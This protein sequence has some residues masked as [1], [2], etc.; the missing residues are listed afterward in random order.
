MVKYNASSKGAPRAAA[1]RDAARAGLLSGL[2]AAV[3]ARRNAAGLT[4]KDLAARADV[5]ERFLVQ[6]EG[7]T[8]N[9][10]VV[11][12][13]DVAAALGTTGAVLLSEVSA[14]GHE[15]RRERDVVALVGLRGAGKSAVGASLAKQRRVPF[16]ELDAL[17]A[18]EARMSL[19]A[20]F[21]I[22]GEGYYRRLEREVLQ[23]VLEETPRCVLAT[24]GSLVTDPETWSLLRGR[25]RTVWLSAS[26]R[27]HW[28]RVVAQG[29]ARPMRGRPAAM[30]ELEDLLA[31]RRPLY[32]MAHHAIDTSGAALSEVVER[33]ARAV[34]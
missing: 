8:G 19:G 3:R 17:V 20:L 2:G 15:R 16:L 33:V 25:A 4:L 23:R 22:H 28:E 18:R 32:K 9:I 24:G 12:L 10:S 14:H 1:E 5:S 21:E 6:L 29:D 11:R 26:P 30:E 13:E 27:E 7:G 31:R 34:A